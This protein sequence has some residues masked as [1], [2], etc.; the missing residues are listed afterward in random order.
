LP[1]CLT[2]AAG[3]DGLLQAIEEHQILILVA[4]TGAGKTTQVGACVSS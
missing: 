1:A 4:E 2:A 3:R